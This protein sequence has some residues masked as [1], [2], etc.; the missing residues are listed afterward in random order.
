MLIQHSCHQ[1]YHR[2]HDH[3]QQ[4]LDRHRALPQHRSSSSLCNLFSDHSIAAY[5]PCDNEDSTGS[6]ETLL[7]PSDFARRSSTPSSRARTSISHS[8]S[9]RHKRALS[10]DAPQLPPASLS[11]PSPPSSQYQAPTTP[12]LRRINLS[13]APPRPSGRSL[14]PRLAPSML[15]EA[16]VDPRHRSLTK[17]VPRGSHFPLPI[18]MR[19]PT[20]Q[21]SE[22][23]AAAVSQS[24]SYQPHEQSPQAVSI[25]MLSMKTTK[26]RSLR[27]LMRMTASPS[28][29]LYPRPHQAYSQG[30]ERGALPF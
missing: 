14:R 3:Q 20:Q 19:R 4:W 15:E 6:M 28:P 1:R 11:H 17:E 10:G 9:D 7:T 27:S 16:G 30:G 22:M 23:V 25:T 24:C 12:I 13:I 2:R 18:P 26:L 8:H 21:G 29:I 5:D